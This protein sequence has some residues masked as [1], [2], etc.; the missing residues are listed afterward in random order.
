MAY[1]DQSAIGLL[2]ALR[3][4]GGTVP[5]AVSVAGYD[6]T[7]S[8]LACFDLTTVSQNAEEQARH[9]VTAPVECLD[10]GRTAFCEIVLAPQLVIRGTTAAVS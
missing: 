2:A 8:R 4:A 9:A 5:G 1:N 10:E 3:R 6:D 7:L